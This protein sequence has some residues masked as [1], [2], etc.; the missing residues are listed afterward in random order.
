M[1]GAMVVGSLGSVM[2]IL[3]SVN[4]VRSAAGT[5]HRSRPCVSVRL[6]E[7]SFAMAHARGVKLRVQCCRTQATVAFTVCGSGKT[8]A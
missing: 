7:R 5:G 6:A 4:S 2:T 1:D 8:V 3:R